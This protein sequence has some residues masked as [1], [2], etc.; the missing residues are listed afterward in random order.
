MG[1]KVKVSKENLRVESFIHS[2]IHIISYSLIILIVSF[3]FDTLDISDKPVILYSFYV[4]CI[5]YILNITV[6]P[7]LFRLTIPIT[8]LTLGLF[9]PCI[10]V[11][12]LK[13]TDFI[14]GKKFETNG[15]ITLFLTAIL[16]SIMNILMENMVIK[17]IIKRSDIK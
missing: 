13:I 10:N 14:L 3:F 7:I 8:G 17:R 4:S 11:L 6:K 16:I 12:I 9:Y 1:T 5:I 15:I 2:I